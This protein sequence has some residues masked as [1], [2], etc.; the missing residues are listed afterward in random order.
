MRYRKTKR[1]LALLAAVLCLLSMTAEAAGSIDLTRGTSLTLTYR[2]GRTPI[3]GAWFGIYRVADADET[4]E[5]H[6]TDTFEP[7]DIDIRGKNDEAWR[8]LALTMESYVLRNDLTPLDSGK[9]DKFGEL[10]FPAQKKT[11]R[12]GL[13][14]VIGERHAQGGYYYD[15]EPFLVMLPTQ[16][17]D[18]NE[19]VYDVQA[20]VKS[21]RTEIP[22]EPDTVTRKVLKVWDDDGYEAD[23][24]KEITVELLRNGKVYDTVKLNTR[25]NWRYTW[26]DLDA[27][28]RWTV[29]EQ[30]PEG[31]S[32]SITR[33][34][35]TFVVTNT[36]KPDRPG[37]PS[38]PARPGNSGGSSTLPQTGVLWWPV[39]M[40]TALGL[41]FVILG[42]LSGKRRT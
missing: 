29:S 40:L 35:I 3:S 17:L 4:G 31:Y 10:T 13:Y 39:G 32:V 36:R 37:T 25:N 12:A 8:A 2:A 7:F 38:T 11:L 22:E 20:S 41:V 1:M 30:T 23:R 18:K 28:A 24:P 14:L 9:T 34:G 6:R 5:L 33:E 21:D 26:D 27:D 19:W 16:D 42:V 15:A